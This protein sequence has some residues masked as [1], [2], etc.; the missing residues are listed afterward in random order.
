MFFTER[1]ATT[2]SRDPSP[3]QLDHSAEILPCIEPLQQPST[4]MKD[5]V[6][7]DH[8]GEV[9][10]SDPDSESDSESC[11]DS[12]LHNRSNSGSEHSSEK[13]P[14]QP[15]KETSSEIPKDQTIFSW[16]DVS[17]GAR[18]KCIYI[19]NVPTQQQRNVP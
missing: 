11:S 16:E 17:T 1:S 2:P 7:E 10:D 13:F 9:S 18:S 12:D 3:R 4:P 6:R 14:S 19:R 5:V 8:S 15:L